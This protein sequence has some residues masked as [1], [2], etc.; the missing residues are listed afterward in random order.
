[1]TPEQKARIDAMTHIELARTW[2]FARTG[3]PL[4]QGTAGEYFAQ[5]L[6][7]HGGITPAISKQLGWERGT[8]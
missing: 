2:R 1:M 3:E 8:P 6:K 4:L 5:R 7:D